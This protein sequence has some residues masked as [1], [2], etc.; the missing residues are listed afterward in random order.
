[1]LNEEKPNIGAEATSLKKEVAM[2]R[3]RAS[4][5]SE[6]IEFSIEETSV[7]CTLTS[8]EKNVR[9]T[10]LK[11][12]LKISN[13]FYRKERSVQKNLIIPNKVSPF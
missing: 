6:P 3:F 2:L 11:P 10:G 1:M 12:R 7:C 9:Y 8:L 4:L 13:N 5:S